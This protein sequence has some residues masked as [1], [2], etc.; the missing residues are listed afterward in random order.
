[1]ANVTAGLGIQIYDNSYTGGASDKIAR[2]IS[3]KLQVEAGVIQTNPASGSIQIIQ[4]VASGFPLAIQGVTSGSP[5]AIQGLASGFPVITSEIETVTN[6]I[7]VYGTSI[8]V[9]SNNSSVVTYYSVLAGTTLMLKEVIASASSGP[10]K[11]IVEYAATSSG[12]SSG[13]YTVGFFSSANPTLAI[14]F[15]QPI[16]ATG[17]TYVRVTMR[18]DSA[19]TQDLYASIIGRLV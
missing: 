15:Y 7:N 11:V 19:F 10:V 1:M 16:V 9:T 18:N 5:L 12:P 14:P 2:I 4:G 6:T 17:P 13:I 8:N 3:G